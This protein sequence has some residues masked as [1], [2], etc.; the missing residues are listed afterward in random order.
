MSKILIIGA[1][2]TI[3]EH[4]ARIWATQGHEFFLVGRNPERLD[5]IVSDLSLRGATKVG[6]L[7]IDLCDFNSHQAMLDAAER[8]LGGLDTVLIA[9]GTLSDQKACEQS[10]AL[11]LREI[12][13][14]GLSVI[15]LLT[16]VANRLEAQRK[17]T[18]A[19][20]SSV[21]GDR[22]RS[23]NYVYGSAK[24]MVTAYTSGLRQRLQKSGVSVVTL[25]PGFIDTRMTE[26]FSKGFL[27]VK[28]ADAAA[29]IT[30]SID[31]GFSEEIYVPYFWFFIMLCIKLIP[32]NL[33]KRIKL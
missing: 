29:I 31:G 33:F 3:A 9:H 16:L 20:I 10:V 15:A 4:C 11:T 13:T 32:E 18:I 23:S 30:R 25:K 5:C 19:V 27:W 28:P 6:K 8:G 17:G 24:A 1:T 22:G 14:N 7:V 2:S 12:E 21:A 26:G